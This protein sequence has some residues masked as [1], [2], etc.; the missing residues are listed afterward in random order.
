MSEVQLK[1]DRPILA[2][3]FLSP[4]EP[5]LRA[6][7]RL[8]VQTILLVVL[9]IGAGLVPLLLGVP[10]EILNSA[11]GN[12]II[13]FIAFTGSVYIARRWLD[14]RSFTS[15]GLKL[16]KQTLLDILAGIGIWIM[17][18]LPQFLASTLAR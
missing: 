3:V 17:F 13:L 4:D 1:R 8:L 11:L 9:G 2:R 14:K 16:N 18:S 10:P 5:R 7:W 15:L 6:G 12:T